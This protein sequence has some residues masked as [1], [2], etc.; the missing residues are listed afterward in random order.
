MALQW[1]RLAANIASHDKTLATVGSRGGKGAMAVYMFA[2]AWSGGQ[3][4]DGYIPAAVLPM[5]HGT[6]ADAALLV[7]AGLW[8]ECPN[9]WRI[10]NYTL[11]QQSAGDTADSRRSRQRGAAKGNCRRWHGLDCG[12]WQDV[13]AD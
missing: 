8:E 12:C 9:G 2:L 5:L 1:V 7:R 6:P 10:H 4:T 11:R 3:A 13:G